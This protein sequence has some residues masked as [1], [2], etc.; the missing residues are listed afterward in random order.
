M[1]AWTSPPQARGERDETLA[2]LLQKFLVNAWFVIEAFGKTFGHE[3]AE[4]RESH[5]IL[6]QQH[7]VVARIAAAAGIHTQSSRPS[8]EVSEFFASSFLS[9]RVRGAT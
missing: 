5:R 3:L 8:S 2:V 9:K 1:R 6:R 4:V 7:Q